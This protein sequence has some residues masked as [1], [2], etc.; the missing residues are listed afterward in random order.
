M[1]IKAKLNKPYTENE[2][3]QF[4]I[5]YNDGFGYEIRETETQ[6]QAWGNTDEE[7]LQ[8]AKNNKYNEANTGAK[9]YIADGKALYELTPTRHIEA[10]DGNIGKFSAYALGYV[11]GQ[12]TGNV[13]WTTKEDE[14]IELNQENVQQILTGLGFIQ[15][16]VWTVK[17]PY[18]KNLIEQ[19][20]T[21]EEVNAIIIDYDSEVFHD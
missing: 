17:F 2:R 19:A 18:Y 10:T 3:I 8:Q 9:F 6:L 4:I 11:T 1:E 7:A 5:Q 12:I 15:A 14:V 13:T 20:Q 21:V 16:Q